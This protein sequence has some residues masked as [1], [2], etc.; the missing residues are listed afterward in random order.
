MVSPEEAMYE[1]L[2]PG[3]LK[4]A[5]DFNEVMDFEEGGCAISA[6]SYT[7]H[8]AFAEIKRHEKEEYGLTADEGIQSPDDLEIGYVCAPDPDDDDIPDHYAWIV[9][10]KPKSPFM[11]WAYYV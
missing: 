11:V 1:I 7:R 5:K 6:S 10:R 8:Q 4:T 9:S 3:F 2:H